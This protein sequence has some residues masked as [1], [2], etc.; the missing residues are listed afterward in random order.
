M[1]FL[2]D[3][4]QLMPFLGVFISQLMH[5]F[6]IASR[7]PTCKYFSP[8]VHLHASTSRLCMAPTRKYIY[9]RAPVNKGRVLAT[10]TAK[11]NSLCSD[12]AVV[13]VISPVT[14]PAINPVFKA[15]MAR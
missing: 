13:V 7:A 2:G 11:V 3:L 15:T 8:R 14:P 5:F 9:V 12:A 6:G 1:A 4:S 10:V